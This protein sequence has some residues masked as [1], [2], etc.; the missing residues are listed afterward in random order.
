MSP[1]TCNPCLRSIHGGGAAEGKRLGRPPVE[2]DAVDRAHVA[3]G[4]GASLRG[5]MQASGV[6][7]PVARGIKTAA[8]Q[9][10]SRGPSA[11]I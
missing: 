8:T 3:L 1:H 4:D 11:L 7:M 9:Q 6:S 5:A 2:G 10:P